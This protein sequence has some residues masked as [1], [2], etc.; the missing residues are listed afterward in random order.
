MEIRCST[1]RRAKEGSPGREPWGP[2]CDS[3]QPRQGRKDD[4]R[5]RGTK[6]DSAQSYAPV[7]ACVGYAGPLPGLTPWATICRP[8]GAGRLA[9]T[10]VGV[11]GQRLIF[12]PF[13][14]VAQP[15]S[16]VRETQQV[17]EGHSRGRLCHTGGPEIRVHFIWLKCCPGSLWVPP[18]CGGQSSGGLVP[19]TPWDLSLSRHRS[20][21]RKPTGDDRIER[22]SPAAAPLRRSGRFPPEPYPP[23]RQADSS[24]GCGGG[25]AVNPGGAGA[26]PPRPLG[27]IGC[28]RTERNCTAQHLGATHKEP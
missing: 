21:P 22:S 5:C 1:A 17:L 2:A 28:E 4:A 11:A 19:Q 8:S 24:A 15:P 3:L 6:P 7:G 12:T 13:V 14:H 10:R 23:Q 18:R 27:R 26:K 16:A 25:R 20:R 9:A